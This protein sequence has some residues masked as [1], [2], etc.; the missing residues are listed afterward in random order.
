MVEA[1]VRLERALGLSGK[2][3]ESL[4]WLTLDELLPDGSDFETAIPNRSIRA[5]SL[6]AGLELAK[7]GKLEIKQSKA[8]A[9][10]YLRGKRRTTDEDTS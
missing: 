7:E 8:F 6:L 1:R 10:I 3:G 9:P 2:N 5:S 4:D